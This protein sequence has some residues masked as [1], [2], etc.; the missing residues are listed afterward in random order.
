MDTASLKN[1]LE[2]L[3]EPPWTYVSRVKGIPLSHLGRKATPGWAAGFNRLSWESSRLWLCFPICN[4]LFLPALLLASTLL[5]FRF[6]PAV[7]LQAL[8]ALPQDKDW[9]TLWFTNF[10][11]SPDPSGL[12]FST[13]LHLCQGV[14][15]KCVLGFHLQSFQAL[16]PVRVEVIAQNI[17]QRAQMYCPAL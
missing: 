14:F 13:T 15:S 8:L 16:K 3:C 4:F 7:S 1:Y 2:S 9:L 5:D 6:L 12:L 11:N 10:L 17:S